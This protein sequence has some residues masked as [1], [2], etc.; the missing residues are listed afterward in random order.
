MNVKLSF[1]GGAG[2]VTGSKYLLENGE[3][4]VLIDCGLFQ[5]FKALRLKNWAPFPIDPRSIGAVVLTH[6]HLDHSGYLPLL[7]KHGFAGPVFCSEATADLCAILLPDSGHLQEK[8]AEFANRHGFSKHRPALPLYTEKDA[9]AALTYLTPVPF[10]KE[11]ALPGGAA[12]RLRRTGH[13]LGA[14]SIELGWAETKIVFSGDLGRYDDATMVDP[15]PVERADYLV[16]ESTYGNRRHDKGDPADVL[17]EIIS[18]TVHRGGTVVIPAFAVGRAQSL[19]FHLHKLKSHG[20]LANIPVFLD[21][22]MAIDA[23][24]IFCRRTQDQKLSEAECR[25]ACAVAQYVRSVDESKAL[26][27]NPMP[28]VIIS[29]S[30]MATGG[31][32]LHHLKAYAPDHKSTILFAGFQAGGTRGAAML[33]GAQ[34]IKIHGQYVSVRAEVSN[35]DMLSAHADADEIL[36]WLSG[37]KAAPRMTFI[38]HGEPTAS[39]ALRQR[40]EE[41]F[42][43]SCTVPDHGQKVELT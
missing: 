8:D 27:A 26:T 3:R 29:A 34:S 35:L 6:A 16:V 43:W 19:L 14:A 2:T 42:G 28:K 36:R 7:I 1:L 40:I 10:D 5:G 18:K 15:V 22:P 20:R 31:R 39:D 24:E 21:S 30:G 12:F 11:Q 37:F 32:V 4:R 38:T 41:K 13:I 23:S 33:A 9:R 25:S 17:D